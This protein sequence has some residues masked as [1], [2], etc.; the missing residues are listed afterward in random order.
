MPYARPTLA[1]IIERKITDFESRLPDANPSL[2]R[3]VF[4][5]LLRASA[6]VEHTIYGFIAWVAKQVVP[7]TSDDEFLVR[8]ADWWNVKEVG[9]SKATGQFTALGNGTIL[10]GTVLQ[11]SDGV[12]YSV[13]SET[14]I[15][16]SGL[17]DIT[18]TEAGPDGNVEAGT[19]LTA[20][21][22][23]SPV[24]GIQ[25]T[26]MAS[27][28]SGGA[29]AE[30]I[31]SRRERLEERVQEPPHGG[32]KADYVRWA[33]EVPGVTRVWPKALWL[34]AGTVGVFFVRDNDASIIPDASEVAAVQDH[35]DEECPVTS[36]VT[37][38]APIEA[39][40]DMTIAISP[41]NSV[42]QAAVTAEL[43]DL[44]SRESNV[45]DGSG[46]GI[47]FISKIREAVSIAAGEDNNAITSPTGNI[48]PSI[49]EIAT[50]G[51]ITFTSL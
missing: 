9:N 20:L 14:V 16:T 36:N 11:R 1:E 7:S 13:D 4:K 21:T 12:T 39:S 23:A 3:S 41:N 31:E 37:V 45:E 2:R 5:A 6:A 48:E 17:V 35:I 30:T 47:I 40:Q 25:S 32:S 27:E 19:P 26:A 43:K 33:K 8:W 15:S 42:V 46:S 10:A 38:M 50:L 24:P 51:A 29:D 18:C 22:F 49:G 44:F 34:G 28:I